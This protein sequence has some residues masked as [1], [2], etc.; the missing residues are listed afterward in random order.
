MFHNQAFVVV[1]GTNGLLI[2]GCPVFPSTTPGAWS[3]YVS[4]LISELGRY[5]CSIFQSQGLTRPPDVA[6]ADSLD[7]SSHVLEHVR[8]AHASGPIVPPS[9][10]NATLFRST[11]SC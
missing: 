6:V 2:D 1:L 9:A 5:I 10:A 7:T 4:G 3:G 8:R 11:A